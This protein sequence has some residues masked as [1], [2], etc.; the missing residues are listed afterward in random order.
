LATKYRL[1]IIAH[2]FLVGQRFFFLEA[3]NNKIELLDI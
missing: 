1:L 2:L 3:G